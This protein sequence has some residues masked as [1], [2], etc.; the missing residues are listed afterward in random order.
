MLAGQFSCGSIEFR[1]DGRARVAFAHDWFHEH[2]LDEHL[3][4]IGPL[5]Q[6]LQLFDIVRFDGEKRVLVPER[7]QMLYVGLASRIRVAGRT[8]GTTMKAAA[9]RQALNRVACLGSAG[10]GHELGVDIGNPAGDGD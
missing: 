3:V 7:G 1:T 8:I 5:E 4:V 2:R 6:L 9:Q 10:I